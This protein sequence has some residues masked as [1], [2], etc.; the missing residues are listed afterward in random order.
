MKGDISERSP[1][2]LATS[3]VAPLSWTPHCLGFWSPQWQEALTL[4][5]GIPPADD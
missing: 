3:E 1:G 5:A 4:R 2:R